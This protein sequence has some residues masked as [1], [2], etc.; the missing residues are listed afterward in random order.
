M[1]L[2]S[3]TPLWPELGTEAAE[4]EGLEES[5]N[6][7][8][9]VLGAGISGAFSACLL[10]EAGCNVVLVDRRGP[11]KGSTPA[12]TALIQYEIDTP[13]VDLAE[14]VGEEHARA[15]YAACRRCLDQLVSVAD[16]FSVTCD[17]QSRG[18]LFLAE[19]VDDLDWMRREARA[20]SDIGI[21]VEFLEQDTV[22]SRFGI[23][24]PGAIYSHAAIELDP[25]KLTS[26]LLN[27]ARS[28]G[29]RL[30]R[31]EISAGEVRDGVRHMKTDTGQTI[32]AR[33]VVVA[34]GY[35]TPEQFSKVR[36]YCK[37]NSTFALASQRMA[38]VPCWPEG[39][40]LWDSADPYFYARHTA[41]GRVIIGGEDEP[42]ADP[43]TRDAMLPGKVK[44][45]IRK[46]QSLLPG[47]QIVPQY[48]WAG[49]FAES[50]DGLPLIGRLPEFDDCYFALGF[51]GNGITFSLIA[52]EVIRD[53][54]LGRHNAIAGLFEF[55]R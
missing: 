43:R 17:L 37:L 53:A 47:I 14:Q 8:V 44:S 35:E 33:H 49:T 21:E 6:C 27:E 26:G 39:V 51:G 12:S 7:D 5:L 54:I 29:V 41:D 48:T 2:K 22:A 34:T 42:F 11:A 23:S 20:R 32:R 25:L 38:S 55:D 10:A 19:R 18:S 13:L 9:V 31:A 52:A 28:R 1:D 3:G 46:A 36:Q 24:R 45:L 15:A 4:M 40:L 30:V 16:R 50:P